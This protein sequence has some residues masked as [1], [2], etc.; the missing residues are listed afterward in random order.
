MKKNLIRWIVINQ[1]PF[2]I[3]EEDH[4]ITFLHSLYPSVRLPTA[5]T[6]KNKIM[7][8][9]EADKVKMETILKDLPGKI[10]FTTDCWTSPSIKSF[11]SLIAHF[12]NKEWELQNII[13]DF[14]QMQDSHTGIN[15][16]DAFLIG[17]KKMSL[18][19]KVN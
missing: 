1:H 12:I 9:Y 7:A 6:I 16:K 3:V 4:F 11:L 8:Y 15:I 10:S 13:I 18:E 19:N 5:D 14:I 17:I 2:T